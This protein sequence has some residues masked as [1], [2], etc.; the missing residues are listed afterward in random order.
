MSVLH[1]W[2]QRHRPASVHCDNFSHRCDHRYHL[3]YIR[4]EKALYRCGRY[5]AWIRHSHGWYADNERCGFSIK[6]ESSL[7]QSSDYVQE[8]IYGYSGRYRIYRSPS[9]CICFC[10]YPAGTVDHWFDYF[11]SSSSDHHGNRCRCSLSCSAL[12]HRNE[13]EWK[14][15]STDLSAE[16]FIRNDLLVNRILFDQCSGSLYFYGWSYDSIPYCTF[17]LCIQDSDDSRTCTF[18]QQDWEAR[19]YSD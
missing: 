3:T 9:E 6:R 14:T 2:L 18:H 19:L 12:F 13:Q 1:W 11:C 8:S 16:W 4:E 5:H 7:C 10:R 15:Y 17:E